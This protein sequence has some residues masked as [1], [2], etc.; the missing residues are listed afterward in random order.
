MQPENQK[1]QTRE[2]KKNLE[3]SRSNFV[4]KHLL[5]NTHH[6]KPN[7]WHL[8]ISTNELNVLSDN[9][10]TQLFNCSRRGC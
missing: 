6:L 7:D 4:G 2:H 5:I 3:T 9:E 10:R 1:P 8:L